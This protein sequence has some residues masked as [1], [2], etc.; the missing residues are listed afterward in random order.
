MI[1]TDVT[2]RLPASLHGGLVYMSS[3]Q[4]GFGQTETSGHTSQSPATPNRHDKN[5]SDNDM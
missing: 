3:T 1:I 2:E 4:I 5:M